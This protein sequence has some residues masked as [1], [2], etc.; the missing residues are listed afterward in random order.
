MSSAVNVAARPC[1][2]EEEKCVRDLRGLLKLRLSK[3]ISLRLLLH[4]ALPPAGAPL[5]LL[6]PP[7]LRFG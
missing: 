3:Q 2:V 1:R 5:L 4:G 6:L 7:T